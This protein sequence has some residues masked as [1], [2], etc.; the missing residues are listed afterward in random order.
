ETFRPKRRAF[1][2]EFAEMA[3]SFNQ[4]ISA[5]NDQQPARQLRRSDQN[6]GHLGTNLLKWR[7]R[8]T[9]KYPLSTTSS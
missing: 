6:G 4:E 5:F 3:F 9:K 8:L 1:G 2:D 7:F